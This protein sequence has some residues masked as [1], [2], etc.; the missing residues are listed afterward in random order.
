MVLLLLLALR[1]A[2][3]GDLPHA[4]RSE[5]GRDLLWCDGADVCSW[6]SS[7]P[8]NCAQPTAAAAEAAPG[9]IFR[10]RC[11]GPDGPGEFQ[12]VGYTTEAG[13]ERYLEFRHDPLAVPIR[14][15]NV[16]ADGRYWLFHF[17]AQ[18]LPMNP[19]SS[20]VVSTRTLR[21]VD[22]T[23]N[24]W[25]A[26]LRIG[27]HE[28]IVRVARPLRSTP[29]QDTTVDIDALVDPGA[30]APQP[31]ALYWHAVRV[32]WPIVPGEP[33][34][35]YQVGGRHLR[36]ARLCESSDPPGPDWKGWTLD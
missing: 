14:F 10:R 19:G 33:L 16:S 20:W 28:A 22:L 18:G 26:V 27:Q 17:P 32:S 31:S 29:R 21:P 25:D 4:W 8:S 36:C 9:T 15:P 5:P 2:L 35:V 3:A 24:P 6:E 34:Q 12:H 30:E 23:L 13:G 7:R 11:G 1:P